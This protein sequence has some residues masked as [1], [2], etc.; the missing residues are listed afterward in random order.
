MFVE[1]KVGEFNFT[2]T[3]RVGNM[4]Y[5]ATIIGDINKTVK[6]EKDS[7]ADSY[8]RFADKYGLQV[9]EPKAAQAKPKGDDLSNA[10]NAVL[11]GVSAKLETS[12][13]RRRQDVKVAST[14]DDQVAR[15]RYHLEDLKKRIGAPNRALDAITD[16]ELRQS[17]TLRSKVTEYKELFFFLADNVK[18][19]FQKP[20]T[21]KKQRELDSYQSHQQ[22]VLAER[23]RLNEEVHEKNAK[24]IDDLQMGQ[25]G[26]DYIR[27]ANP[28]QKG[29]ID[30]RLPNPKILEREIKAQINAL[31][32]SDPEKAKEFEDYF[33]KRNDVDEILA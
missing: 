26:L 27:G 12:A 17:A 11:K 14:L 15:A 22:S 7:I 6:V 28:N 18:G 16:E 1:T 13:P 3:R 30:P 25:E 33:L 8:K 2:K 29:P 19:S 23:L 31:K 24:L 10:I 20:E 9:D 5:E 4:G 21:S 32:S